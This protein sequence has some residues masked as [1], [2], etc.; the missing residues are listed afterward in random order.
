MSV[1]IKGES[2]GLGEAGGRGN[3]DR[4]SEWSRSL[5]RTVIKWDGEGY[6]GSSLTMQAKKTNPDF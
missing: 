1:R 3:M 5:H 2:Q 6:N 4:E